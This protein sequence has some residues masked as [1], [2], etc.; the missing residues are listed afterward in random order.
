[1]RRGGDS[2]AGRGSPASQAKV[3]RGERERAGEEQPPEG[4]H[5]AD[6]H[7]RVFI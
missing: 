2:I 1:M 4:L 3:Q 5:P 6:R 7:D